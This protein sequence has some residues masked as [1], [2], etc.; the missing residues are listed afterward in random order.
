MTVFLFLSRELVKGLL[1][2]GSVATAVAVGYMWAEDNRQE[3][4]NY[5]EGVLDDTWP[6]Y[7]GI[8]EKDCLEVLTAE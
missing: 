8:F 7:K 1:I 2:V 4:L 3:S 6:D 5:C